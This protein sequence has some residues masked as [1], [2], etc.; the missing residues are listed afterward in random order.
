MKTTKTASIDAVVTFCHQG[1]DVTASVARTEYGAS[2]M[3]YVWQ[4]VDG[5]EQVR[6]Q[7]IPRDSVVVADSR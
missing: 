6:T 4:P 3:T 5:S 2:G 7:G 1:Q